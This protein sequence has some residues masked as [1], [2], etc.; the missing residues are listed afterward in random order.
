M[1]SSSSARDGADRMGDNQPAGV[2]VVGLG[3]ACEPVDGV[4]VRARVATGD[5]ADVELSQKASRVGGEVLDVEA[6]ERD[7]P[8]VRSGAGGECRRLFLARDAPG[9][10]EVDHDRMAAEPDQRYAPVR[11][12]ALQSWRPGLALLQMTGRSKLC[13]EAVTPVARLRDNKARHEA[14]VWLL[15]FC[16][17]NRSPE[18]VPRPPALVPRREGDVGTACSSRFP[19]NAT[20]RSH[21]A[22]RTR[23][24][25]RRTGQQVD[26]QHFAEARQAWPWSGRIGRCSAVWPRQQD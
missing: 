10:P 21:R 17:K 6:W 18:P 5:E 22:L 2:D 26:V 16:L 14:T 11:E 24:V 1:R 4:A 23:E 15:R 12:G 25:L 19:A 8:G 9:G 13:S 7:L 20:S 3:H